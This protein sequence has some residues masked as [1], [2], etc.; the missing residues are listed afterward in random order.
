MSRGTIAR[1][2]LAALAHNFAAVCRLAS[3]SRVIAVI[4]A[5]AY[6]HGLLRVARV[7]RDADMFAVATLDEALAIRAAGLSTPVLLLE[8]FHEPLE[9]PE[10]AAQRF[11]VVVHHP[12]QVAALQAQRNMTFGRI[13]LKSDTG[14]HRLGLPAAAV[15]PAWEDLNRHPGIAAIGL[16]SHLA[17]ADQPAHPQNAQQIASFRQTFAGLPG[18]RTLANSAA[19]LNFPETRLDWVRPG[20]L[21]YGISPLSNCPAAKPVQRIALKPVMSLH[22]RLIAVHNLAAGEAVG[23]GAAWRAAR[24]TRLGIAA[25]G[26]GDGYSRRLPSGVPVLVNGRRAELAGHVSM[27]MIAIALPDDI[28]AEVGDEVLLWGGALPVEEVAAAAGMIPYELV[29]GITRRVEYQEH[30]QPQP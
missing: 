5:D 17:C 9:L 13:W 29:C 26:Y 22:S 23:Y 14:M 15:R 18:P 19:L 16:M 24:P 25:I 11:D 8:G 4:K 30:S 1:L 20:L 27:D 3:P 10:I 28:P 21:L 6:G 7:L 2:D 12:A